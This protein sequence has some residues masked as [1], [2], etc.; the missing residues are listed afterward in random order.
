M[1]SF[2]ASGSRSRI[3]SR[4]VRL[5][6]SLLLLFALPA[7]TQTPQSEA[8]QRQ[9]LEALK[10][11]IESLQEELRS[12]KSNRTE[13]LNA[14]EES[15]KSIGELSAKARELKKQLEKQ[16]SDLNQLHQRKDQLEDDKTTQQDHVGD[17]IN[18][19]Y[20]LGQQSR[21]KLLLN[22]QDPSLVARNL[23]YFDYLTRARTEKIS[24]YIALLNELE[25]VEQ[26]I[27][28]QNARLR[29]SEEQ[30][31][32]RHRQLSEQQ[33]RRKG[34]LDKLE[35]IIASKDERLRQLQ[36]DQQRLEQV[37]QQVTEIFNIPS[38]ADTAA[39]AELKGQLP[40]PTKGRIAKRFGS[41]RVAGK[42]RWQGLVIE[43]EAGTPVIAIHHG[44]VVFSDYLRGHGL[45]LIIDHGTGYMSLYGRNRALYKEIGEWV[46]AGDVI[47]TVGNSGG[48]KHA[49]LYFEL[50]HQGEPTDPL[51]WIKT[52]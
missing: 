38:P 11:S 43:A 32:E 3:G 18:A 27:V 50:R 51:S 25:Q 34:T 49:G 29:H 17:H 9:K 20:R 21:L 45:L 2:P 14:L 22:Q 42:M 12:V 23:K 19:V 46:N 44:R 28:E 26:R 4:L 8:E 6:F 48:Q 13:L 41:D 47:A 40:W 36:T 7:K 5:L 24:G 16:E 1:R 15:E 30:L 35:S 39:F 33:A 37:L 31:R 10:Q 52:T